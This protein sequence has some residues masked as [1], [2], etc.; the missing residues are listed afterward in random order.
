MSTFNDHISIPS[1]CDDAGDG[2]DDGSSWSAAPPPLRDAP[3]VGGGEPAGAKGAVSS[4]VTCSDA[5][6]CLTADDHDDLD[7]D[8][9]DDTDSHDD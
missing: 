8:D 1:P 4:T 5:K 9:D 7:D 2:D 6:H 3:G